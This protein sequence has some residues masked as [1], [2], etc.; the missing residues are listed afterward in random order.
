MLDGAYLQNRSID[1]SQLPVAVG[2]GRYLCGQ[3]CG[4]RLNRGPIE[5]HGS[6]RG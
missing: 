4:L 2:G 1:D 3:C 6:G 5:V